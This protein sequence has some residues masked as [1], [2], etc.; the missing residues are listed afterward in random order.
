MD[1]HDINDRRN[2]IGSSDVAAIIGASPE[3]WRNAADVYMEK[4][5]GVDRSSKDTMAT[6]VGNYVEGG[7]TEWAEDQ[8][9]PIDRQVRVSKSGYKVVNLDGRLRD[10]HKIGFECKTTGQSRE[11]GDE[12]TDQIPPYYSAQV[13]YQMHVA[14][15]ETVYV[16]VLMWQYGFPTLKMYVIERS[17]CEEA[18]R[19]IAKAV[20]FFWHRHVL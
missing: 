4:R 8:L 7:V 1:A 17:E 14:D 6:T 18:I 2:S 9:G 19:A 12:W 11:W 20:R 10:D 13:L 15:L 16:P 5:Y 3:G